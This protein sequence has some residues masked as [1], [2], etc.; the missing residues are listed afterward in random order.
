[1]KSHEGLRVF[2]PDKR[3]LADLP[4]PKFP[5]FE[6]MNH[7]LSSPASI[8]AT[9]AA[10]TSSLIAIVPPKKIPAPKEVRGMETARP[11]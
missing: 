4:A 6:R 3:L 8:A 2:D 7:F 5:G 9:S 11:L 10:V 1:M